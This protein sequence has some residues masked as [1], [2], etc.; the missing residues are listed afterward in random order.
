MTWMGHPASARCSITAWQRVLLPRPR[1][2]ITNRQVRLTMAGLGEGSTN[3][4]TKSFIP[5][6]VLV[7][8]FSFVICHSSCGFHHA[9]FIMILCADDY[10]LSEDIDRAILELCRSG[11]LTAVSCMVALERC[12]ADSL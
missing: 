11:R 9:D 3:S 7:I 4:M 1:P 2:L 12:S 6:L 10:G 5:C 8:D